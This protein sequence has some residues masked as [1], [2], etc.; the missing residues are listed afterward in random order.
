MGGV[1]SEAVS[2]SMG[3]GSTEGGRSNH[4]EVKG[5]PHVLLQRLAQHEPSSS[6]PFHSAESLQ[7]GF[8]S[9][10]VNHDLFLL[11]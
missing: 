8:C 5:L 11:L 2:G 4:E 10:K 1:G 6:T 7:P 3:A 9:A